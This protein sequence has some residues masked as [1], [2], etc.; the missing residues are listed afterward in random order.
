MKKNIQPTKLFSSK[1]LLAIL[2]FAVILLAI[3]SR[4]AKIKPQNHQGQNIETT[5]AVPSSE[6]EN[7]PL[8]PSLYSKDLPQLDISIDR[9]AIFA[10]R[11]FIKGTLSQSDMTK[12]SVESVDVTKMILTDSTGRQIPIEPLDF[13]INDGGTTGLEFSFYTQER[14]LPGMLTL[15]IPAADFHFEQ[16]QISSP[17]FDVDFGNAPQ[18]NQEWPLNDDFELA[19]HHIHLSNV[20]TLMKDDIPFLDFT[21]TAAPEVRGVLVSDKAIQS[22]S[23]DDFYT[24]FQDGKI[25]T[26]LR[27]AAGFPLEKHE[28]SFDLISFSAQG[29]W[30]TTFSP[31]AID[32]SPAQTVSDFQNA[33]FTNAKWKKINI[34]VHTVIP[35]GLTG[36]LLL[37]DASINSMA[38]ANLDSSNK[39]DIFPL[40]IPAFSPDG[41]AIVGYDEIAGKVHLYDLRNGQDTY[42]SWT[43]VPLQRISW[44]HDS[45]QIAYDTTAGIY[46]NN[47]D[48]SNAFKI[49]GT[50]EEMYLGGWMPDGKHMLITHFT[51]KK[52]LP[53]IQTLDIDTGKTT[54]LFSA[55]NVFPAPLLSSDGKRVIYENIINNSETSGIFVANLDGSGRKLIVTFR[56]MYINSYV[57]SPDGKWIIFSLSDRV[58]SEEGIT[59]LLINPDTCEY[60]RLKNIHSI[61]HAWAPVP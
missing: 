1:L 61:V 27:Y 46:V 40:Q 56:Y 2:A 10:D 25:I 22:Y 45:D 57:W 5:N 36:E 59:N 33:C 53:L 30:Q 49:L 38:V 19:G 55:T 58:H 3:F 54:D 26:L 21:I 20:K 15:T 14:G 11:Y 16:D 44:L 6:G 12:G 48:G 39:K 4:W 8:A 51:P 31:E 60:I 17:G 29:N 35:S 34:E 37:E 9:V 41:S 24:A 13:A 43:G 42:V 23:G 18:E 7:T 52:G 28:F 32:K 47:A 50:N